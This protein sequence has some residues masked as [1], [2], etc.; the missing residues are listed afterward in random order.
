MQDRHSSHRASV[1]RVDGAGVLDASFGTGGA[2]R[3]AETNWG[4]SVS[5]PAPNQIVV[6][7]TERWGAFV[8]RFTYTGSTPLVEDGYAPAGPTRLA[9][10]AA[11]RVE[12]VPATGKTLTCQAATWSRPVQSTAVFWSRGSTPIPNA[13]AITYVPTA[14][15]AG[16]MVTCSNRA[17][18]GDGSAAESRSDGVRIIATYVPVPPKPAPTAA[19]ETPTACLGTGASQGS[20][21]VVALQWKPQS[22]ARVTFVA[23]WTIAGADRWQSLPAVTGASARIHDLPAGA[24]IEWRVATRSATGVLSGPCSGTV[25]IPESNIWFGAA[26][27]DTYLGFDGV[28]LLNGLA[29]N[30]VIDGRAGD[31]DIEGGDGNDVLTGG[32]GAD[33]IGGDAG[34]DRIL[35]R[36]GKRDAVGCGAGKDEVL[37]DRIDQV[38][39]DCEVVRR[40]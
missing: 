26:K 20:A 1:L 2:Y 34:N 36:D 24:K 19:P 33:R 11:P 7:G 29:G 6:A 38:A 30:D 13:T 17:R 32:A 22:S 16:S 39:E 37:A 21:S 14:A 4:M 28:D 18:A 8:A 25:R 27:G 35:V 12:G 23:S 10:I 31:D 9:A 40:V 15:D 3:I 5:I